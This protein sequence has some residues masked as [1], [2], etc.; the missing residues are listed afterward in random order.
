MQI[1]TQRN[2]EKRLRSRGERGAVEAVNSV[3][4]AVV[5][6]HV[7]FCLGGNPL[8]GVVPAKNRASP[9]G[10]STSLC[11]ATASPL[12]ARF[13]RQK[14]PPFDARSSLVQRTLTVLMNT[15][16]SVLAHR[17]S[18]SLCTAKNPQHHQIEDGSSCGTCQGNRTVKIPCSC[19][20]KSYTHLVH[21]DTYWCSARACCGFTSVLFTT[22]VRICGSWHNAMGLRGFSHVRLLE[23]DEH[24]LSCTLGL[25]WS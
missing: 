14:S 9:P 25:W 5:L 20:S 22:R 10:S 11:S 19:R 24:T 21:F 15:E 3:G 13:L 17:A 4:P 18:R 16:S 2:A 23:L 8:S 6:W 7:E 1:F 12:L